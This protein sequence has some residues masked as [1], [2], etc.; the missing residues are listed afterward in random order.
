MQ[1]FI[2]QEAFQPAGHFPV[3]FIL[4]KLSVKA[5]VF[6]VPVVLPAFTILFFGG[7]DCRIIFRSIY[8]SRFHK[9]F[10]AE[11]ILAVIALPIVAAYIASA[12]LLHDS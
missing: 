1:C 11:L 3:G 2:A 10:R 12:F 8:Q 9:R 4:Q 6:C 5:G 7:F